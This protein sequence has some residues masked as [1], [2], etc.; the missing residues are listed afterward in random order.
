M[1]QKIKNPLT[2]R[3]TNIN[4]KIG[5]NILKKYLLHILYGGADSDDMVNWGSTASGWAGSIPSREDSDSG[6]ETGSNSNTTE[7]DNLQRELDKCHEDYN[8]ILERYIECSL[9]R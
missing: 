4:S 7:T 5:K 2:N 3:W 1:Y 6:W 8:M 9:R